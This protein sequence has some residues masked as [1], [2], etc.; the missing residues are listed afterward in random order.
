MYK[1]GEKS[2]LSVK[3]VDQL[4]IECV[5]RALVK[6]KYDMTIPWMGGLR[7]TEEQQ[8]IFSEG[9]SKCDGVKVTSYHQTGNA[10]D[11]I[12]VGDKPYENTRA[13][14]HFANLMLETW[15]IM[16]AEG[17]AKKIM[18]WGGTFGSDGWDKPHFEIR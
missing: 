10:I 4:L 2:K 5:E 1:L 6:S 18:R 12:P 11:V 3:G 8:A 14:N 7:T 13:L 9:H 15:Q 17:K 16:I